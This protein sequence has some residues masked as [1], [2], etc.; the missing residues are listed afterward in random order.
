[1]FGVFL[2]AQA[3]G[4]INQYFW[5]EAS[6][7]DFWDAPVEAYRNLE[8]EHKKQALFMINPA[9]LK[10]K[11]RLSNE[12]LVVTEME[13]W[14]ILKAFE[15]LYGYSK[16]LP[17][18]ADFKERLLVAK[19]RLSTACFPSKGNSGECRIIPFKRDSDV[20]NCR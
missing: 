12:I 17:D 15:M 13:K 11:Y 18:N 14:G 7:E 1:M 10:E 6:E 5:K 16:E 9:K 8:Q 19:G 3:F 4:V 2:V 20:M